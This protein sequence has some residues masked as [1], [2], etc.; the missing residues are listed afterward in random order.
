MKKADKNSIVITMSINANLKLK[1]TKKVLISF[2]LATTLILLHIS[3]DTTA[4]I[5]RIISN[6]ID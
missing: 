1:I 2:T 3:P 5:I 6:L 4:D